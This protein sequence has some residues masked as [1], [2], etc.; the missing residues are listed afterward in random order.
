M[1]ARGL[2][3]S[4]RM[5]ALST[6]GTEYAG[7]PQVPGCRSYRVYTA[8]LRYVLNIVPSWHGIG[9]QCKLNVVRAFDGHGQLDNVRIDLEFE[10]DAKTGLCER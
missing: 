10:Q 2:V 9:R 6:R 4:C 8:T 5:R 7:Q 1:I 3:G